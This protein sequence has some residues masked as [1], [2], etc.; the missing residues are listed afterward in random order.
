MNLAALL[1]PATLLGASKRKKE[2]K[3]KVGKEEERKKEVEEDAVS[4]CSP[5]H[6]SFP[7]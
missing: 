4:F 2:R 7:H 1:E 6:F 5:P 3:G